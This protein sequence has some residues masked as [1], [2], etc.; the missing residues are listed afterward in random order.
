MKIKLKINNQK[1]KTKGTF[2][3]IIILSLLFLPG[4]F[5]I[6]SLLLLLKYVYEKYKKFFKK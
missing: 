2:G 3:D 4:G 6:L 5:V 1:F